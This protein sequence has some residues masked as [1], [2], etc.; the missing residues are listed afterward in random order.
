MEKTEGSLQKTKTKLNV[1]SWRVSIYI[2]ISVTFKIREENREKTEGK[3]Y[4]KQKQNFTVY[5]EGLAFVYISLTFK[6]TEENYREVY[7]TSSSLYIFE[8]RML[9]DR[10]C[11][12]GKDMHDDICSIHVLL[13]SD[14]P[15]YWL[16]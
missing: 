13:F 12:S 4:R 1:V 15:P 14:W 6:I 8:S 10:D 5:Q 16:L 7:F 9:L 11:L 2:Y 3:V